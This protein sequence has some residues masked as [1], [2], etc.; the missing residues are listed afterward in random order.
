MPAATT[1]DG[2]SISYLSAGEGPPDLLC[3]HG[4]GGS[5]RYFDALI[6][7]LDLTRLRAVS[8][9]LRGHGGSDRTE[10]GYTLDR[11]AAS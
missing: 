8:V 6:E 11:I 1:D 4:W 3:M 10:D 5:A 9:D 2:V 7:R